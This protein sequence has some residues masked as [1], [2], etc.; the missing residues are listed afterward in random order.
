MQA[1]SSGE[2]DTCL[3]NTETMNIAYKGRY[4]EVNLNGD[5][6][7]E[8]ATNMWAQ[9][10]S[11]CKRFNCPNVLGITKTNMKKISR[12]DVATQGKLFDKLGFSHK[13]RIAWV[14][15]DGEAFDTAYN[16]ETVLL[17]R[18]YRARLFSCVEEAKSWLLRR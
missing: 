10:H 12:L 2:Q 6:D 7:S 14:E 13:H 16:I 5:V 9:V 3:I 17:N 8:V 15:N 18:G 11:A 4:V 1:S